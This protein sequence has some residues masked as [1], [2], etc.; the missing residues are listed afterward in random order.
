VTSTVACPGDFWGAPGVHE[1]QAKAEAART[2][3]AIPTA[4]STAAAAGRRAAG[5]RSGPNVTNLR[6]A[7]SWIG[8]RRAT[9]GSENDGWPTRAPAAPRQPRAE[10]KERDSQPGAVFTLGSSPIPCVS[11]AAWPMHAGWRS[12]PPARR[13]SPARHRCAGRIPIRR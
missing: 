8:T 6:L 7:S 9:P 2:P 13:R 1:N 4:G 3:P 11:L 12:P 10:S 5:L